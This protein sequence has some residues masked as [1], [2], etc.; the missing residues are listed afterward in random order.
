MEPA[1]ELKAT[2][3]N[4][5]SPSGPSGSQE[6]VAEAETIGERKE[7]GQQHSDETATQGEASPSLSSIVDPNL[8]S[9]LHEMGFSEARAG[10]ALLATKDGSATLEAA[11]AWLE[12]HEDDSGIDEPLTVEELAAR[13]SAEKTPLTEEEAQ[14]RAY[15]LQKKLREERVKREKQE[16]IEK[17]RLRMQQSKAL[18][19]QQA[20]LEE[21]TRKRAILQ[22]QKEK[23][24]AKK[25][26]ERQRELLRQDYRDRFGCEMPED[27][28]P[29]DA[30]DRIA[31]MSAKEKVAFYSNALLK[32]YRKED[33]QKLLVCLTTLRVYAINAKDNPTEPKYH[34]IRQGLCSPQPCASCFSGEESNKKENA[35]FKSRVLP[36]EGVLQLLDACGFKDQG[37]ALVIEG[38]PDGFVLAQA[39][40][41][42]QHQCS[43]DFDMNASQNFDG[44]HESDVG[45]THTRHPTVTAATQLINSLNLGAATFMRKKALK[46]REYRSF[47]CGTI[48]PYNG[49][50]SD[51]LRG[52]LSLA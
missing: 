30:E 48:L 22:L 44:P 19:E 10:R 51:R 40:T 50:G 37:D 16:A 12:E 15:E 39:T 17:E 52:V 7:G 8:L 24:E 43:Y 23:E 49:F 46:C 26:R 34:R 11:L 45:R 1:T 13:K 20:R 47:V 14:R 2:S 29:A 6:F 36:C 41:P 32:N 35:A 21:E 42:M 9:Q 31:K 18:L 33:P 3:D 25:E 4:V 28:S 27:T 5:A 38:Q